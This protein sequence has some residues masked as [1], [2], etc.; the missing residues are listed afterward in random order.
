MVVCIN[1]S[2]TIWCDKTIPLSFIMLL[3]RKVNIQPSRSILR[4]GAHTLRAAS[5]IDESS[6]LKFAWTPRTLALYEAHL[7]FKKFTE[8]NFTQ[9]AINTAAIPSTAVR[10]MR[11]AVE[12]SIID[13]MVTP[14]DL[15][16]YEAHLDF[17]NFIQDNFRAGDV[18]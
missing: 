12:E 9:A 1:I 13:F 4:L 7:A 6:L 10:N 14:R 16:L 18:S 5:T 2:L 15:L 3:A 8:E 17:K 11:V